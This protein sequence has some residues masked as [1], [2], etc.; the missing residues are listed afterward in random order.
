MRED[1]IDQAERREVLEND[2]LAR[3]QQ[4]QREAST[5]LDQYHSDIGGRFGVI[6][7]ETVVGRVSPQ[8]PQ[9][10]ASSPW[11][12][13]QPEPGIEPPLGIEINKLTPH[14][15]EP[16]LSSPE[17]VA[18]TDD[19][20][21]APLSGYETGSTSPDSSVSGERA[22]SSPLTDDGGFNDAA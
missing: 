12:G 2:R 14:E 21:D 15:L 17:A 19:S 3:E 16:S 6:E 18:S 9:L 13:L 11:S 1:Q 4:Q 7:H 5:Y 22:G 20:A 10:P 8:L